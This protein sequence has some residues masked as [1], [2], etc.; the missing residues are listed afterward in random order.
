M[1]DPGGSFFEFALER[2]LIVALYFTRGGHRV[3][4]VGG[5][6]S[7]VPPPVSGIASRAALSE[8]FGSFMCD[9]DFLL[10]QCSPTSFR[11]STRWTS[12]LKCRSGSV[13]APATMRRWLGL[14]R[15][16]NQAMMKL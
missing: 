1:I 15:S 2:P 13:S 16:D 9:T 7:A 6:E 12:E 11:P 5:L 8:H 4:T 10:V 14:T 3:R